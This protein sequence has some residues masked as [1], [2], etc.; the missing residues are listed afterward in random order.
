[1]IETVKAVVGGLEAT[2][3]WK[4]CE[5][6]ANTTAR[7]MT[8]GTKKGGGGK[9]N[10]GSG[11]AATEG[12]CHHDLKRH[13]LREGQVWGREARAEIRTGS[14]GESISQPGGEAE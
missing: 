12:R 9:D 2:K 13:R 8:C 14:V 11:S 10:P 1:M 7:G 5:G 4:C 6:S 3:S